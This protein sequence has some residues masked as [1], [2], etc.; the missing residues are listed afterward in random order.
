[1]KM[2]ALAVWVNLG[3]EYEDS[4]AVVFVPE[5]AE[6]SRRPSRRL[7]AQVVRWR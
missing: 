1:M 3:G 7:A 6:A 2:K 4:G 5:V